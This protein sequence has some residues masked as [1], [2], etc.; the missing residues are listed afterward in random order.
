VVKKFVF[1]SI[2]GMLVL[3]LMGCANSSSQ[4]NDTPAATAGQITPYR[5]ATQPMS[6]LAV[7]QAPTPTPPPL[8]TP[9][10][11]MY[12][13]VANDTMIAIAS[14]FGI[15]LDELQVANPEVSP[16]YLSVGT[17]L[18]IPIKFDEE[19]TAAEQLLPIE[20]GEIECFQIHSGGVWCYWVVGNTLEHPVENITAV[21]RLYNGLGQQVA[22]KAAVPLLNILEAGAQTPIAVFFEPPVPSWQL[23]QGQLQTVVA[24]NQF[25]ER[26]FSGSLEGVNVSISPNG[27]Q[28][29]ISGT[30]RLTTDQLPEYVWV[31]A[32]AYDSEDAVVGLRR[33]EAPDA[34]LADNTPA[35]EFQVYSLG[36]PIDHVDI[37]FEAR[38]LPAPEPEN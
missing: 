38:A 34:Q 32:V 23:A 6:T 37:L 11:F 5:T 7:T 10:P 13:V 15:T 35:F 8:P 22:S 28:A 3:G 33:W 21:I 4:S 36:R 24:A 31:Q 19:E 27:L 12:T 29:D 25:S 16:N 14:R 9:T 1:I 18:V 26:Y 17:Q 20:E 2:F 30:L